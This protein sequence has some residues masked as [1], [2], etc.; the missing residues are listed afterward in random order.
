MKALRISIYILLWLLF[1]RVVLL[2]NLILLGG[3]TKKIANIKA[4][5]VRFRAVDWTGSGGFYGFVIRGN[6]AIAAKGGYQDG[7][8]WK[9]NARII[10]LDFCTSSYLI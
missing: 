6:T 3:E 2:S 1:V 7:M 5:E 4:C 8:R 10:S 9:E